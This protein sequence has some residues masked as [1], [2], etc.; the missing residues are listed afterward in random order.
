MWISVPC[1]KHIKCLACSLSLA[2]GNK[3]NANGLVR[4][5]NIGKKETNKQTKKPFIRNIFSVKYSLLTCTQWFPSPSVDSTCFHIP[6]V[7]SCFLSS[8]LILTLPPLLGGKKKV[9]KTNMHLFVYLSTVYSDA[10]Q[11]AMPQA[12]GYHLFSINHSLVN[13]WKQ[14]EYPA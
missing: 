1:L 3:P 8:F 9:S 10:L 7:M 6:T 5:Y 12:L 4:V 2:S 11:A 14:R 13:F